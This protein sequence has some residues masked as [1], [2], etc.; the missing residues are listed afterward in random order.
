MKNQIEEILKQMLLTDVKLFINNKLY[1]E[2]KITSFKENNY[3]YEVMLQKDN[4]TKK[5]DLPIPFN[6]E[7]HINEKVIYFDYR[8][9]TLIGKDINIPCKSKYYNTILEICI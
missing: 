2:G 1:K 6:I 4:K 9:K 3:V 8:N 5:V 7:Q